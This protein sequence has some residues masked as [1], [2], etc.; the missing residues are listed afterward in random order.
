MGFT[1][2]DVCFEV[3]CNLICT[4]EVWVLTPEFFLCKTVIP[5]ARREG[6]IEAGWHYS[7]YFVVV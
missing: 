4:E 1:S 3:D 6:E 7:D 5:K 2:V